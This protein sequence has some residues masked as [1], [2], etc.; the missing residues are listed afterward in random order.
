M[1]P[2]LS[3]VLLYAVGIALLVAEIFLPSHLL[4]GLTGMGFLGWALYR[5][6]EWSEPAG[7]VALLLLAI[8]LPMTIR[9]AIR[10]WHRTPIGRRIS[11]PNPVLTEEDAGARQAMLRP[12]VGQVGM[13]LTPLRPVG[14]CQFGVEKVECVAESGMIARGTAV[15]A[16]GIV[17]MSLSVRPVEDAS[18]PA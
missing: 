15:Q 17:N 7:Y 4:I 6:F 2:I 1:D 10:N 12:F 8:I 5:T 18:R 9:F 3:L 13:A 11:P 16:I 14:E